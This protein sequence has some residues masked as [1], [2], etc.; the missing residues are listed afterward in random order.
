VTAAIWNAVLEP[1]S[2]PVVRRALL[3]VVLLG[4]AGGA[5]GCWVLLYGLAYPSESL[6]HAMLPGLVAAALLG[7][8]ILVGGAAGLVVAGLATTLARRAPRTEPD[9]AVAVVVTALLGLGALLALAP[10][11][12]AG[13]GRLLFGDVL[14]LGEAD[15]VLAAALAAALLVALAVLHPALLAVGFDR[16][17]AGALGRPAHVVDAILALLLAATLL[18]A[19][20]GLGNLLVVALLVAPAAAARILTRRMAPMLAASVAIAVAGGVAGL[21]A[22]YHLETAAGASIAGALVSAYALALAW[23]GLRGA[24]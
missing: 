14:G 7:V 19:V 10:A 6:A 16:T 11:T 13:L 15:L 23:R 4:I 1:W 20:Q 18:V 21:E 12:P 2:E 8:P 24:A 22:S 3:E 5:L 17:H 9:T